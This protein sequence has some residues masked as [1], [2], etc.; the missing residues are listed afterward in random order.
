MQTIKGFNLVKREIDKKIYL[1]HICAKENKIIAEMLA[2]RNVSPEDKNNFLDPKL[3]NI[4]PTMNKM[5]DVDIAVKR[6]IKSIENNE[7]ICIF[8]DY[9]VDG[10]TSTAMWL[11][12]FE[13]LGIKPSYYIPNRITE[14]YGPNN[15]AIEKIAKNG[16]KLLISAD[17]GITAFEQFEKASL[18]G[19]DAIII[20]HHQSSDILP[21]CIACVNP[22][23]FDENDL[24]IEMKHLCACGVS[25]FVIIAINT[26]LRKKNK[27]IELLQFTPLVAF[28]TICDVMKL[29]S[30]NRAFIK[31]GLSTIQAGKTFNLT[32][33]IDISNKE[34]IQRN[35]KITQKNITAYSFGF[36]LGPMIN[37]GGRIGNSSLG[38]ELMI[39][40]NEQNAENIAKKLFSLNEERKEIESATLHNLIEQKDYI[41][42]QIKEL[43]YIMLYSKEWH[44]GVIGLIAS[45]VKDKYFYPVFI[46]SETKDRTIKFSSRSVDGVNIGEII[47][48]ACEK[49][50]L[51]AGGGHKL[52]GGLTC[53][54]DKIDKLKQFLKDKIKVNADNS[55][56][57][58]TLK[59]DVALSLSGL[60]FEILEKISKFE[61]FG[62]GNAKPIFLIQDVLVDYADIIKD[63]HILL[64]ISDSESSEKA[65]CFN[66]VDTE[67]GKFLF[68][69]KGKMITILASVELEEYQ[70]YKRKNIKIEDAILNN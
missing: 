10:S 41:L 20:D 36:L 37:A 14:G 33:L 21:K 55:F 49:K 11:L 57:N 31:T 52:A 48:Q 38:T 1:K 59:Y 60:T 70:G 5:K 15:E 32:K 12:F 40:K 58:K 54:I 61:P 63:K 2:A 24:K 16:T 65:I 56:A 67:L 64:S 35:N 4:L 9:D 45:R 28:A 26:E 8:G 50:L 27:D 34:K 47:I 42:K 18:L 43:G 7:K 39:E 51:V 17:C 29:T 25:F 53:E 30:L 3:R 13:K 69:A 68:S 6:I 22:N 23:R 62:Q 44:E 66:S 46:G 19:I